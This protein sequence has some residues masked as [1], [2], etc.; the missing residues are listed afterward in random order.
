MTKIIF[1]IGITLSV[2]GIVAGF[3]TAN[4]STVPIILLISGILLFLISFWLWGRKYK[5]WQKRSTKQGGVAIT[6]TAT[7]LIIIGLINFLGIRHNIR[8]DLTENKLFTLSAQSKTVVKKLDKSLEV[9]VFDRNNNSEL[10]NLL[11]N[12]RRHSK[13]FKFKF[14]NPEQEIGLAKQYGVQSLGEIYLQYGEKKQKL[15][16]NNTAAEQP[17]TETQLTNGIE[18]IKRDRPINIYFLQGH[19]EA[20]LELVENGLA[21]AVKNLQDKGNNVQELNLASNGIIPDDANLIII[22]GATRKL[23]AA[24]VSSLQKYLETGGNLLL[25]LSPNIDIGL[26]PIYQEWGIELDNRLI[27]D[28]SGAGSI[29]GFGPAVALVN[30]YG[31]HPITS[32]FRNGISIFPESRPIK[33]LDQAEVESIPLATTS[34]QTW[35]END[36]TSEEITFDSTEDLSGPLNIAIA[37]S[38]QSPKPSRLVVFGSSTF[39]TNG[40]FEQQLNGDILLNSVSWLVGEDQETLSIRPKEAANRRINLS[41]GQT[42]LISWLA[43]RIMPLL[44]LITSAFL[45][46]RRR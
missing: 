4:W 41:S 5:F 3:I 8:W 22:A 33:T 44:A 7:V 9:L 16:T 1:F 28:G 23:L 20:S 45:W 30:N 11:E 24:E 35:A 34:E 36:L 27:V 21:Q 12:Y 31:D 29:M 13:N 32:S 19:G 15:N 10:E 17:I 40:W 18:T 43:L 25:L 26:T 38:R 6:T 46:W 42:T 2:A 37:F 39:A 14:I